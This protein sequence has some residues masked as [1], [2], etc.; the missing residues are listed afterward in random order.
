MKVF[1]T[2][3][4]G[5]I[6]SRVVRQLTESGH[7]VTCLLRPSSKTARIDG[8]PYER[9]EGDVRDQ[10]SLE[11]GMA[12]QDAVIHL[13]SISSWA[14]IRSDALE[15][16]VIQGTRHAIKAAAKSNVGRFVHVSSATAINGSHTPRVFN[17]ESPFGLGNTSLR[18]A[19]AKHETEQIVRRHTKNGLDSVIVNPAEVYGP[20]DDD[21]VTAGNLKDALTS[22]PALACHGGTA[23]THVDDVA[24]GVVSA[25]DKGRSEERY[26]L[27]GENLSVQELIRL[28]LSIAGQNKPVLTLPNRPMKA[29]INGL[30]R[31]GLPTPV[32]PEVLDYATYYFF[33]DSAKAQRE[34]NYQ[35][36][37]AR[38]VLEPVITW[39][40]ESGIIRNS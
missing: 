38:A 17:E 40:Y 4:N 14:Q 23:I 15:T 20:D 18:Y 16:V 22:W 24:S 33:V 30:S 8:L 35:F 28:T 6:G 7:Q 21:F 5:F 9:C 11:T 2:G 25:L 34:L 27:G 10:A 1:V 12:G 3:G 32:I 13:A 31:I 39:L 36:R 37:P 26:I 29:I 19:I